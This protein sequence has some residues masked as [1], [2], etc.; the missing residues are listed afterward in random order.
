MPDDDGHRRQDERPEIKAVSDY[1]G[2]A[3]N[4]RKQPC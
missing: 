4:H 1:V 3:L 2:P